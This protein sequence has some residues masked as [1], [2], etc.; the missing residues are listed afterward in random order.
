MTDIFGIKAHE[1][2]ETIQT[3]HWL[4]QHG[5]EIVGCAVLLGFVHFLILARLLTRRTG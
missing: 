1:L 5:N 4:V 2:K 3:V